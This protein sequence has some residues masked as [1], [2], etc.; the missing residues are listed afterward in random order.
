[1]SGLAATISEAEECREV[2]ATG[3]NAWPRAQLAD[4][5]STRSQA[6][7]TAPSSDN[8]AAERV[9]VAAKSV[10]QA[11]QRAPTVTWATVIDATV[12][13]GVDP[14]RN[15]ALLF[16]H[17]RG[18]RFRRPHAPDPRRPLGHET[19]QQR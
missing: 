6:T 12:A 11:A 2:T 14:R 5:G 17:G 8:A 13:Y 10:R 7:W 4:P 18:A 1:M 19:A 9:D 15:A 16:I 3:Q